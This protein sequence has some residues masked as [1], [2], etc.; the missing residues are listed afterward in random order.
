MLDRVSDEYDALVGE[1]KR[2]HELYGKNYS[3]T[4]TLGSSWKLR[5]W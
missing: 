5:G 1:V 3:V 4:A 2:L